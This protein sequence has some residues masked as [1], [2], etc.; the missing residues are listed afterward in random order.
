MNRF[1]MHALFRYRLTAPR[2]MI[3]IIVLGVL[4]LAGEVHG[5]EAMTFRFASTGTCAAPCSKVIAAEGEITDRTPQDFLDFIHGNSLGSNSDAIIFINSPGGKVVAAME[6]GKIFR[7]TGIAAAVARAEIRSDNR[8]IRIAGGSCFSACVY[9]LMGAKTRVIPRQSRV[10]LH[11]MFAYESGLDFA[12]ST[13]SRRRRLD[14][15]KVAG[16]LK[17]YSGMMG[18]SPDLVHAAEH[19]SPD[20]LRILSPTEISKWR[21]SSPKP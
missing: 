1:S 13:G 4:P 16:A 8:P 17:R 19:G 15:G 20:T 12:E 11:R 18:I 21:L 6:L 10:G 14:D 5:E 3:F 7:R 2:V 9:A